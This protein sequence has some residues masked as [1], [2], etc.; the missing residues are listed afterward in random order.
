MRQANPNQ[1]KTAGYYVD[2]YP[3]VG[4]PYS[5]AQVC[6]CDACDKLH[7]DAAADS[8]FITIQSAA[9]SGGSSAA[10]IATTGAGRRRKLQ[11]TSNDDI[12]TELV[13]VGAF[14]SLAY[15]FARV[16]ESSRVESW[17]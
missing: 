9:S 15:V 5:I 16:I 2:L 4:L 14:L 13:K 17:P 8:E 11:A 12:M 10:A 6:R 1:Y 3:L 7:E